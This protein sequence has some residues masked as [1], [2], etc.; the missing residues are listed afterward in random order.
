[1]FAG[2]GDDELI[3][4]R[5]VQ[6]G[7]APARMGSAR[8]TVPLAKLAGAAS[9]RSRSTDR[10]KQLGL[11][12]PAVSAISSMHMADTIGC[13]TPR[14]V[15]APTTTLRDVLARRE[16]LGGD[17][18]P[19]AH[20]RHLALLDARGSVRSTPR[21]SPRTGTSTVLTSAL[22]LARSAD[23]L[24]ASAAAVYDLLVGERAAARDRLAIAARDL[25]AGGSTPV[26]R[27]GTA[28]LQLQRSATRSRTW[29]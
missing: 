25:A 4:G 6:P 22:A 1:M 5:E 13:A 8:E 26:V 9:S 17:R 7:R 14:G 24:R 21:A 19:E 2:A 28:R 29:A 3:L 23:H 16:A 27:A 20:P 18:A 12:R 15:D 11:A 10:A